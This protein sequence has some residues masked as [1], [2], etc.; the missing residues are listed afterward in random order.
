MVL[1]MSCTGNTRWVAER[2]AAATGDV[3]ANILSGVPRI[4][5]DVL[6]LCFP[7][8]GWRPP[9]ILR[10]IIGGLRDDPAWWQPQGRPYVCV[11]CTAGDNIGEAADLVRADLRAIGVDVDS[12]YSLL[13]PESYVNLPFMDVDTPEREAAKIS[14]AAGSLVD[15]I[16][17]IRARRRGIERTHRG[18]WPRINS[19]LL[20]GYFV[21]RLISDRRFSV[22]AEK[23]TG[24]GACADACQADNM[25]LT[26]DGRP[27][28]L[29]NGRCM[30]CM[31]CYH[32]CP[33][34]AIEWGRWTRD[35][36]Q[37]FFGMKNEE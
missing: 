33:N 29:H 37:Y 3:A 16:D 17:D 20:G 1:Y 18:R 36:G 23:C 8:H 15:I 5:D 19:R 32:H 34:H 13:M 21:S 14:R 22:T 31:A 10:T 4:T 30:T 6:C 2:I 7:V 26:G 27:Q 11:V 28:W 25:R 35:K 24:C 9:Q 12:C